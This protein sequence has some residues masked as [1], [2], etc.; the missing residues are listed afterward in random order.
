MKYMVLLK[1]LESEAQEPKEYSFKTDYI[2]NKIH[3]NDKCLFQRK[4]NW[5]VCYA[6]SHALVNHVYF[7]T[8]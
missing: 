8:K 1:I 5:A 6:D 4:N 7:K 3:F 2:T